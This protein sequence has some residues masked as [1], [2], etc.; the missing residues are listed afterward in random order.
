MSG[1][2]WNMDN[3]LKPWGLFDSNA[4]LP[5]PMDWSQW[6]ESE[7]ATYTGHTIITG[8]EL[9]AVSSSHTSGVIT[10]LIQVA[11]GQT[12]TIGKK[13]PVTCRIAATVGALTISDDRTV[14]LKIV[15]R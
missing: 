5:I 11:D 9:E 14:Y 13:Y 15:E 8:P 7:G 1:D 12:A 6:I 10:M 2:F 4:R 3:P